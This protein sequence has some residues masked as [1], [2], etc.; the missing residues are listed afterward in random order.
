MST[1]HTEHSTDTY[2]QAQ[3]AASFFSQLLSGWGIPG[4]IARILAGAIIGALAALYALSTAGCTASYS[5]NAE[6][7]LSYSGSIVLPEPV[8]VNPTK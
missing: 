6:G 2:E 1:D 5:Q 8:T 7:E 3:Q 4:G